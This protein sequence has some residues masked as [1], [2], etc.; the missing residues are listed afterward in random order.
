MPRA[1]HEQ[2]TRFALRGRLVALDDHN[3]VIDD[4]IL[5]VD[6]GRIAAVL[7]PDVPAPAGFNDVVP[8]GTGGIAAT[9]RAGLLIGLGSDWSVSGGKGLLGERK[10]A[11][12]AADA[13]EADL[14][15]R[16]SEAMATRD[17]ARILRREHAV[18][19]LQS[20]LRADLL[21]IAGSAGDPCTALVQAADP[22]LSLLAAAGVTRPAGPEAGLAAVAA[23]LAPAAPDGLTAGADA[24]FLSVPDHENDL[25]AGYPTHLSQLLT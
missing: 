6:G 21:V 19:A 15:D 7:T 2:T 1:E 14:G 20:G 4:G 5:Y 23:P 3:T 17:A 12:P 8:N 16:D 10:A 9:R 11:R 25:P 18:G 22:R 13:G 24:T